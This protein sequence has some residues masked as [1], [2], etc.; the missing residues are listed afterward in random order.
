MNIEQDFRILQKRV[1]GLHR[2]ITFRRLRF[3]EPDWDQPKMTV[4]LRKKVRVCGEEFLTPIGQRG[5]Q[6][7]ID[8][9]FDVWDDSGRGEDGMVTKRKVKAAQAARSIAFHSERI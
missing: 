2:K 3:G 4:A 6:T 9:A 5:E 1:A 7:N 8:L